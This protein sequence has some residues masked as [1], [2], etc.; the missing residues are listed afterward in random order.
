MI[1]HKIKGLVTIKVEGDFTIKESQPK[2]RRAT[3]KDFEKI[4]PLLKEMNNSHLGRKD[5]YQLFTNHW[6][7]DNFSPG[8]ILFIG[9]KI[10]GFLGTIYSQQIIAGQSQRFCNLTTWIVKN[11]YRSHSIKMIFYLL[12]NQ[13]VIFTSFSSNDI[14]Y[15]VY[16][17]LGFKDANQSQRIVYKLPFFK[18]KK[19]HLITTI[20]EIKRDINESCQKI[21]YD[22]YYFNNTIILVQCE[23]QQCLLMG[24]T[25]KHIFK[26]YY[27][28]NKAIFQKLFQEF[29]QQLMSQLSIHQ[30][31]IDEHLLDGIPL[32]FSRKVT[33]GNPYQVKSHL[34][35]I[36]SIS[37]EYS[38]F[39]LLNM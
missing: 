18:R 20:D 31:H 32:F 35:K 14:V 34:D 27:V 4:Y 1:K 13:Q 11:E 29:Y 24:V 5:W 19:Y 28:S 38:E 21:F 22:H 17:K 39:F 7:V 37:P 12:K 2:L 26:L 10:V 3:E 36:V 30:I 33:W 25:Q 23:T 8:I 16:K 9:D 6:S 15:Q